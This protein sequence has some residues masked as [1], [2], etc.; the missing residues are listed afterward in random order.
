M[1]LAPLVLVVFWPAGPVVAQTLAEVDD[2]LDRKIIAHLD[3]VQ[4]LSIR[5]NREYCGMVGYGP[6]D[7]LIITGPVPGDTDSCDSGD[8]P[9]GFE[10]VASYHT[11]G[12][13]SHDADAEVPSVDDL[14]ADFDEGIDG[15]ISTPS[16]RV[17]LNLAEDEISVLLC[18]PGCV[19]ADPDFRPCP[20]M[21]PVDSYTI[22]MLIE[23]ELSDPGIC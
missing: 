5:D 3:Q 14:E 21:A 15:Y 4:K 22:D 8:D 7:R 16:G 12:A 2:P 20:A 11:H 1:H 19:Y 18:G 17:W 10:P 6:D 9:P 13:W 23:R